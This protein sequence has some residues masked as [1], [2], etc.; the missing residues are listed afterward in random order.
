MR[1][2]LEY[3][4]EIEKTKIIKTLM[5]IQRNKKLINTILRIKEEIY[6]K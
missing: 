5:K 2:N 1:D 3:N 4:L 6:L